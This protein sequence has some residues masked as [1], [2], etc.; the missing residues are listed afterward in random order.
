MLVKTLSVAESTIS[1][2]VTVLIPLSVVSCTKNKSVLSSVV[3]KSV[4]PVASM[5]NVTESV[6]SAATVVIPAPPTIW[7]ESVPVAAVAEPV[8]PVIV[9]YLEPPTEDVVT[10]SKLPEV[11]L[12]CSKRLAPAEAVKAVK[13]F[14]AL[15]TIILLSATVAGIVTVENAGAPAV[16]RRIC[17]VEPVA[18]E[19][20]DVPLPRRTPLDVSVAAPV[21]PLATGRIPVTCVVSPREPPMLARLRFASLT[22]SV[23]PPPRTEPVPPVT[24]TLE[25]PASVRL[26]IDVWPV[27]P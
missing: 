15:A 13:E 22:S 27:P 3:L 26:S 11:S 6:P 23:T 16:P 2:A 24:V 17:P 10:N 20:A 21:P 9:E 4:R 5:L 25:E 7:M 18:A 12:Y 1:C 8:S 14:A 19:T